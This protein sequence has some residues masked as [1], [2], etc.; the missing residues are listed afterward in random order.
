MPSNPDISGVR[1]SLGVQ[2]LPQRRR[3]RDDRDDHFRRQMK[4]IEQEEERIHEHSVLDEYT[5][6]VPPKL[7]SAPTPKP[8][9]IGPPPEDD[10]R[11]RINV[12]A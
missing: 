12:E 10:T 2:G 7:K 11:K 1:A 8:K 6:G 3:K 9:L 4:E 5:P